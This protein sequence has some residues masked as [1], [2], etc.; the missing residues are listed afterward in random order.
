M[1]GPLGEVSFE[2]LGKPW[3]M[4]LGTYG[5]A[6][7]QRKTGVPT[8]KF[9]QR[10]ADAWGA[11]DVLQVFVAGLHRHKLSEE[12]VAEIMDDL[13]PDRLSQ[14]LRDALVGSFGEAGRADGNPPQVPGNGIGKASSGNGLPSS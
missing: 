8:M 2:A 14:V 6:L 3:T 10:D 12:Q 4:K 9:I 13:G 11:D 1:S 5:L 7:L